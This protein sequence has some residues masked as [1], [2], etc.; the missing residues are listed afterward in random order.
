MRTTKNAP[1][2]VPL[3]DAVIH[4]DLKEFNELIASGVDVDERDYNNLPA[5]FYAC[6]NGQYE[7]AKS[8]IQNGANIEI[9]DRFGKTPLS[10]AVFRYNVNNSVSDGKLI[11]LLIDAGA[12]INAKNIA[13]VSPLSLARTIAGFPFLDLF[14]QK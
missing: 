9:K 1:K 5:L 11:K 8:L 6:Q 10:M 4:N 7:M 2:H 14:E 12:D 13:G 3:C